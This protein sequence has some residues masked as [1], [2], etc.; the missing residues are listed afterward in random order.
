MT[1]R[2]QFEVFE[3]RLFLW[4]RQRGKCAHC[5]KVHPYPHGV[6]I[7]H[8]IPQTKANLARYGERVIHHTMNVRAV[9]RGSSRCNSGVAI[10]Q[11]PVREK[12]L[13]LKINRML[14]EADGRD[15]D[16]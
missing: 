8:I 7:A 4:S 1:E 14:R 6:E 16:E 13:V 12:S 5:G 3:A 10:G 11:N 9:C 2:K 15:A